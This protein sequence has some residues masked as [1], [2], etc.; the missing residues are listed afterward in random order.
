MPTPIAM[1]SLGMS[2]QEGRVVAWPLA[3]GARV[4]R[5]EIV[6][7]IESEKAEVEIEATASGT[8]RHVYVE[9]DRTVPCGT[10]LG[11]ITETPDEPFDADAFRR[12]HDRPEASRAVE[13]VAQ[14]AAE[15]KRATGGG[16]VR[17][18]IAPAARARAPDH[19]IDAERVPGTGP[20]GR[21]T[22]EDVEAFAARRS[23]RIEVE[24]GVALDVPVIGQGDS[25]VLLPGFGTDLAAFA[26]QT[27]VLAESFR[28][29]GV[30]P[31]GVAGSDAPDAGAY[32]V[33]QMAA[34]AGRC[35]EGAAHVIG[36]SL[37]AAAAIEFA[38]AA[39]ERV[40]SLVLITPFV[41]A[42]PRLL[43]V[44]DAWV[45]LAREASP[46]ALASALLPW[47]FGESTFGDE[48]AC[49]RTARGLAEIAARVSPA[50]LARQAA[51]LRAWSG[52]RS[53]DLARITAPAL[54]VAGG[55]DLLVP[56]AE[57]VAR[58]I[59]QARFVVAE[60]A[61]HAVALEAP[62]VVNEAIR[63]RLR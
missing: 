30:S 53:A 1:P 27:T 28:V 54:V 34:D 24:R 26:R 41:T 38:L 20:G 3:P 13:P 56:D 37:G 47:L 49:R 17:K 46:A 25:V 16:A 18:P 43:A 57:A 61:G 15:A 35:F 32:G 6:L 8:F 12:D 42:S 14:A 4:E 11:A 58:S 5:G 40:R 36:A 50:T 44:L 33:A 62:G 19:R 45:A 10:L 29:I 39:P 48:R 31:R 23:A 2:M 55:A 9:V 52:T 59:P 60:G 63:A 7:V 22:R 51:G 21:V